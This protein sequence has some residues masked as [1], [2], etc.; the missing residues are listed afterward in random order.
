MLPPLTHHEIFGTVGPFVRRGRHVDLGA[1]D[2]AGRRIAF[3][4]LEAGEPALRDTLSLE[5]PA[6]G[7]WRLTRVL[8]PPDGP[9]ASLV[10]EGAEPAA[11]LAAVTAVPPARQFLRG[12]GFVVA[13]CHRIG[14]GG[15]GR[16]GA[17]SG[18]ISGATSGAT[19]GGTSGGTSGDTSD[20]VSGEAI[21]AR[22]I[23][24][25]AEARVGDATLSMQVPRVGGIPADLALGTSDGAGG[26]DVP[27]D[28]LAVLGL[29][30]TRLDRTSGHWRGTVQLK[31]REPARSRDAQAKLAR[32][33]SHLAT[34]LAEPPH[35]FH[36]RFAAARWGVALRRSVPLLVSLALIAGAAAFPR[37]GVARD[38]ALWMLIFNA[39][40]LLM[41]LFF[42]MREMPRIE[43]PPL[44]RASKSPT[45]RMRPDG[46]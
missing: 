5:N 28:L 18:A 4:V 40:P 8:T 22:L 16:S 34:T 19:S 41:V 9:E 43:I 12:E 3:R 27:A 39:P 17:T 46:R 26:L 44:P 37:L 31:S 2:R 33:V 6:V 29:D 30:W 45:W 38:S 14:P 23:L 35:R 20:E 25:R 10:A 11:L 1:S 24:V 13:L 36:A 42:C 15:G 32:T 7:V 21:E